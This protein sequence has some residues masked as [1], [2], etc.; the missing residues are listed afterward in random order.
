MIKFFFIKAI[1]TFS[2]L[3]CETFLFII[4]IIVLACNTF[5]YFPVYKGVLDAVLTN[6]F[7]PSGYR[8]NESC[9]WG[10]MVESNRNLQVESLELDIAE[11]D[12]V[13]QLCESDALE[14]VR[15]YF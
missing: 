11:R 13:T 10:I 12:P 1:Q 2:L 5:E 3:N 6:P 15:H 8:R 9:F 14:F 4:I 7:H